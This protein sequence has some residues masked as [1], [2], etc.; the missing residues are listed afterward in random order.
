MHG[1]NHKKDN[2]F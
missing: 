2:L 1:Q